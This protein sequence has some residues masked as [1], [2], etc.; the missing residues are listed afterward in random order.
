M[1]AKNLAKKIKDYDNLPVIF[2]DDARIGGMYYM[3]DDEEHDIILEKGFLVVEDTPIGKV[4]KF[5]KSDDGNRL[6]VSF[7]KLEAIKP[8]ELE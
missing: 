4:V 7:V 1:K 8:E 2:G 5:N 6:L 3:Q